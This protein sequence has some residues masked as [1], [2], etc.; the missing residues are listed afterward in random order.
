[1]SEELERLRRGKQE[2]ATRLFTEC[3]ER[4]ERMIE[5]RLDRRLSGRVDPADVLQETYIEMIHR[6]DD[7]LQSPAV[8]FYVWIRQVAWQTVIAHHRRHLGQKRD[9]K[10]EV[11]TYQGID[12]T[13]VSIARAL[14]ANLTT[15][16]DA[17]MREEQ[18]DQLRSALAE[19]DETDREVL[20]LRHFEQ[21]SNNETAEVLGL[22]K[23]AASNRYVRA[24]KRLKDA[25][26]ATPGFETILG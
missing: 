19:M 4:I 12:Q 7:Y 26:L 1:M 20:A 8:C 15:P 18:L 14:V 23:T 2:E 24:L 5:F 22:T 21:L 3:A 25:L 16:S 11:R 6:L 9:P 13:S 17:A 10:Q